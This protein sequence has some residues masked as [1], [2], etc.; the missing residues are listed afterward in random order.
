MRLPALERGLGIAVRR[1]IKAFL[2]HRIA[3]GL[4]SPGT[5]LPSVRELAESVG[6]APMTVNKV[7][8]ELK[9]AGLIEARV[10]A[11][12]YVARSSLAQLG[13]DGGVEAVLQ[14]MDAVVDRAV[15]AGIHPAALLDILTA[16]TIGRLA[17][18]GRPRLLMVGLFQ[19]ATESYA[20]EMAAQVGD[21]AS[22]DPLVLGA[23]AALIADED[24]RRLRE[25]DLA[26]T[27]AS[28]QDR[29]AAIAPETPIVAIRFI[30]AESTRLALAS[31]DPRVRLV[32][33]SRFADF[34]PV[35]ELGARR[36]APHVSSVT[37][38]ELSDPRL[39]AAAGACDAI[40]MSTG[41]EA[42]GDLAPPGVTRIE[43]RHIPDPGDVAGLVLPHLAARSA[44][45]PSG[46]DR[47]V[48]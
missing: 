41:A 25:A 39:K 8:A 33:V 48:S 10:G 34:L 23:E 36:F 38:L 9:E 29:I 47:E 31:L 30:P 26:V 18:G 7:Y 27:F 17:S 35:L 20:R 4:L 11:G 21:A 22:V 40:V 28:L 45:P 42:A 15:R 12:T 16:R 46:N 19:A 37:A 1:Q 5:P 3:T 44:P 43:Y 6:V 2:V 32:V 14:E 24:A 13:A